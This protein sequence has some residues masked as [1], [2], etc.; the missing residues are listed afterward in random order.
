MQRNKSLREAIE[1][2]RALLCKSTLSPT[3]CRELVCGWPDYVGICYASLFGVGGVI[4]G[5]NRECTPIVFRLQWPPDITSNVKSASNLKRMIT[6]SDLETAGLLLL[7]LVMED[8]V[9]NLKEANVALFSD[10]TSTVSWVT[11]LESR[12]STVAAQL[13]AALALHLMSH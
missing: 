12:H 8:V 10:N 13:I 1:M 9:C 7:L 11:R 5:K 4:V 2:Y 3:W 6:N